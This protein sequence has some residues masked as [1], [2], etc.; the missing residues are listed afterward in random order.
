MLLLL[1][2][3]FVL[4]VGSYYVLRKDMR[5]YDRSVYVLPWDLPWLGHL[6]LFTWHRNDLIHWL[7][8]QARKHKNFYFALPL[9]LP[10]YV[11]FITDPDSIKHVLTDNFQNYILPTLRKTTSRRLLGHGIFMVDGE[12]WDIQRHL[13]LPMFQTP[14]RKTMVDVFAEDARLMVD[15]L[16]ATQKSKGKIDFQELVKKYTLNTFGKIGFGVE[17]KALHAEE[18]QFCSDFDWVEEEM[19]QRIVN[20]YRFHTANEWE[21]RIQRMEKFI[22][23][24]T[25]KRK[26]EPLEDKPDLLSTL[27]RTNQDPKVIRDS[28]MNFFIAG[29]DTTASLLTWT[30]YYLSQHPDVQKKVAQ[31][32]KEVLGNSPPTFENIKNL[33]YLKMVLYETLRLNPPALPLNQKMAAQDDVLPNGIKVKAGQVVFFSSYH[34]HRDPLYWGPDSEQFLPSRWENNQVA[35]AKPYIF[36][37]FF[38]GPRTCLGKEMAIEEAKTAVA[39]LFQNN[40]RLRPLPGLKVSQRPFLPIIFSTKEP[41]WVTVEQANE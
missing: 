38:R 2:I 26:G 23:D 4:F 19:E 33:V 25:E 27:M 32:I 22:K 21:N 37:P 34:M 35:K 1:A 3:V 9:S 17:L 40:I 6:L 24:M 30:F 13:A 29:R 5:P 20:V 15:I 28:L 39:I 8:L 31:E 16:L 36:F 12:S 18:E 41:L 14:V 7:S 10:Q 11:L